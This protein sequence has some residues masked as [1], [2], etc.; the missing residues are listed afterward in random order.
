MIILGLDPGSHKFGWAVI[1]P[2]GNR[3]VRIASGVIRVGDQ[4]HVQIARKVTELMQ[5]YH[6]DLVAIEEPFVHPKHRKD[7]I[8]PLAQVRGAA[9]AAVESCGSMVINLAAT[10]VKLLS[11][12]RGNSDKATV[13]R[14]VEFQTGYSTPKPDE[15]DAI[16]IGIAG[17]IKM[18]REG[19]A[20]RTR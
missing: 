12:G 4:A 18:K 3:Y 9:L 13:A 20:R 11:T 19:L 17:D 8:I 6:P 16:A 2:T 5:E 15:S 7:T 10:E 14:W 1:Q